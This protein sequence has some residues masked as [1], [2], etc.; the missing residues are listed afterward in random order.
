M[1]GESLDKGRG[2]NEI[3]TH[4]SWEDTHRSSGNTHVSNRACF[5]TSMFPIYWVSGFV[6]RFF[7][8][9]ESTGL[10]KVV[11]LELCERMPAHLV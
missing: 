1:K 11:L 6:F 8:G 5:Q 10:A 4:F 2:S 7:R 3:Q 9:S